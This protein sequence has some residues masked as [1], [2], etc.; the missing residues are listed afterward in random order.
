[1]NDLVFAAQQRA[2]FLFQRT[3]DRLIARYC[4][5]LIIMIDENSVDAQLSCQCWYRRFRAC[6]AHDQSATLRAQGSIQFN[7]AGM[8]KGD[9]S[10]QFAVLKQWIKDSLVK[11]ESA[12]HA[13]TALQRVMQRCMIKVAQ[14]SAKPDQ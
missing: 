5:R 8:E 7:K 4:R 9:A 13:A 10:I 11:N 6:M 14:V 2:A 1:M 12:E 3:S